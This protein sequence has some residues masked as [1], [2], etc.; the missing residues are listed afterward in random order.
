MTNP[1]KMMMAA[2]AGGGGQSLATKTHFGWGQNNDGQVGDGNDINWTGVSSPVQIGEADIWYSIQKTG[3]MTIAM[4]SNGSLWAWGR[5]TIGQLGDGTAVSKSSPVQI[6]DLTD[7]SVLGSGLVNGY[8]IKTDGTLWAWGYNE[9]GALGDGTVVTKSSP[10]QVGSLTTWA[11]LSKTEHLFFHAVK[12]DGTLWAWGDNSSGRL[13]DG[14]AVNKSSPVQIGSSTDWL[15][16]AGASN[17]SYAVKTDGTLWAWGLNTGGQMGDG[18]AVSK[19]SPVQIGSLT[20]WTSVSGAGNASAYAIKSDGT[21]WSWGYNITGGLG[22]GDEVNRSSPTQVGSLT[23]WLS[24]A[25]GDGGSGATVLAVKTDGTLWG[26]GENDIG[27][28]G[29]GT[30][31]R[32]SS[33]IQ[34]GSST[35][36]TAA[37]VG[38]DTSGALQ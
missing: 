18:T 25:A 28:L 4:Q 2:A 29:D 22:H 35:D 38:G 19:S 10:V 17:T 16:V 6:G 26:W 23:T 1:R 11:S 8:A 34:I 32:K 33:P 21:L 31:V 27:N 12:T 30:V 5:N 36:W 9:T 3:Q 15:Q 20:T 13:G 14:T 37:S 24:V 7:W